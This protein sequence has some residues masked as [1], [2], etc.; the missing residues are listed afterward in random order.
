[1]I[2]SSTLHAAVAT[3]LRILSLPK[4]DKTFFT[5]TL[6]AGLSVH[7]VSETDLLVLLEPSCQLSVE[8]VTI[9]FNQ[10]LRIDFKEEKDKKKQD[11]KKQALKKLKNKSVGSISW[12]AFQ[13]SWEKDLC[14]LTLELTPPG[15]HC[16]FFRSRPTT[17]AIDPDEHKAHQISGE[18]IIDR[19]K[20]DPDRSWCEFLNS[21]GWSDY[22]SFLSS[23]KL[24]VCLPFAQNALKSKDFPL[25]I[26]SDWK[27]VLDFDVSS[28]TYDV[29]SRH[30]TTIQKRV[31][32][33]VRANPS[34]SLKYDGT[35][36]IFPIIS[37]PIAR[38]FDCFD[39]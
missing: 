7:P 25:F 1:M 2:S 28:S 6:P 23:C 21:A 17:Y 24:L 10:T 29:A 4:A 27:V 9:F 34:A 5:K 15:P 13:D 35:C 38:C 19:I 30:F 11:K 39:S 14:V 32:R 33:V 12:T 3:K 16:M 22:P 18:T 37:S 31:E 36:L 8:D 20:N 26:S